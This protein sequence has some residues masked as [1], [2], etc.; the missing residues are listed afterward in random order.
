MPAMRILVAEDEA[1]VS[2]LLDRVLSAAGHT[3]TSVGSCREALDL[4]KATGYDLVLLD[5][6]LNDGN[7]MRVI[8]AMAE[9]VV[10][11][12]PVVLMTGDFVDA[13]DPRAGRANAILQKPFDLTQLEQAIERCSA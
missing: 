9:G 2:R 11:H 8:E 6:H 10:A 12:R 1:M 5:L 4:L 13:D 7:G 3:V